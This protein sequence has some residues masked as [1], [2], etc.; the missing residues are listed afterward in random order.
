M[1]VSIW[2]NTMQED[3]LR[4]NGYEIPIFPKTGDV[5]KDGKVI[6]HMDNFNGLTIKDNSYVAEM[7]ELIP[8]AGFW[9]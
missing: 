5:L 3:T 4:E 1:P 8:S 2:T 6:G 9:N 7:K